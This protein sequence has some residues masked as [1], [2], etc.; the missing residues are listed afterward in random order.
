MF[1]YRCRHFMIIYSPASAWWYTA[2]Y[3]GYQLIKRFLRIPLLLINASFLE[4]RQPEVRFKD[5]RARKARLRCL[6]SSFLWVHRPILSN[7]LFIKNSFNE[8]IAPAK[9]ISRCPD[10]DSQ[11]K[12]ANNWLLCLRRSTVIEQNIP[13]LTGS[14]SGRSTMAFSNIWNKLCIRELLSPHYGIRLNWLYNK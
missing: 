7:A 12:M 6:S 3:A 8:N 11:A 4:N 9:K 2:K 13:W 10:Q 5:N 14:C 1:P